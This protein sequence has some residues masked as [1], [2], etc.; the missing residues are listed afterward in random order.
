MEKEIWSSAASGQEA[1][2]FLVKSYSK[3]DLLLNGRSKILINLQ[4]GPGNAEFWLTPAA[5]PWLSLLPAGGRE[6]HSRVWDSF[7]AECAT[8]QQ[9][10]CSTKQK[11][12]L[13]ISHIL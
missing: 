13:N 10:P 3:I 8:Q 11:L 2:H 7:C 5:A 1:F 12:W 4:N 6:F 9:H